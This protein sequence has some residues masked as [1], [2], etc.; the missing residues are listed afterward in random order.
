MLA[1]DNA[2]SI[3]GL[4]ELDTCLNILFFIDICL[5]FFMAYY[6]PEQIIV[7]THRVNN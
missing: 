3:N 1:F 5:R 2:S 4:F 6:D 7:D